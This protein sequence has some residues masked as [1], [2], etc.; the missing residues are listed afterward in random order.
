MA[1]STKSVSKKVVAPVEAPVVQAPKAEA[2]PSGPPT[3]GP[4]PIKA[5]K[6]K[7][8]RVPVDPATEAHARG[9]RRL[10]RWQ[11]KAQAAGVDAR[12]LMTEALAG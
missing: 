8:E 9:K 6:D 4:V 2:T 12:G 1:K 11:A 5:K 3:S 7:V 10:G